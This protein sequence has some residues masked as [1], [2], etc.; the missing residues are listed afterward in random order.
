MVK[1]HTCGG[2]FLGAAARRLVNVI[3]FDELCSVAWKT[4]GL[5]SGLVTG[6]LDMLIRSLKWGVSF[7]E[8]IFAVGSSS[9][10]SFDDVGV[11]S[12]KFSGSIVVSND[13]G[14]KLE[15]LKVL[16]LEAKVD[17]DRAVFCITE[18]V[19]QVDGRHQFASVNDF[20]NGDCKTG[21]RRKIWNEERWFEKW[22]GKHWDAI[23]N[24]CCYIRKFI[25]WICGHS[26]S[27]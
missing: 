25:S 6:T 17:I 12:V 18:V 1:K 22:L 13:V 4:N 10:T 19:E 15:E 16:K 8:G 11:W 27:F 5:H 24:E 14:S 7:E 21:D 9:A 23:C 20:N 26:N 3:Q 2:L